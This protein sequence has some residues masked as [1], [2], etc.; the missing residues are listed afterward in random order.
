MKVLENVIGI[1]GDIHTQN[2]QLRMCIQYM[3]AE[4]V[5]DILCTGDIADGPGDINACIN[6]IREENIEIVLGNHDQWLMAE[7]TRKATNYS[8]IS[9]LSDYNKQWL[10]N[11][12]KTA[13]FSTRI[14][15][16]LLCHGLGSNDM[17]SLKP[18]DCGYSLE[19]NK[20]FNEI[21]SHSTYKLVIAGH[22]HIKMVR[23]IAGITFINPGSLICTSEFM[24]MKCAERM[25]TKIQLKN[26]NEFLGED[27]VF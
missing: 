16:M 5:H 4:N 21:V 10:K 15:N 12:P 26:R 23:T 2:I 20:E 24:I 11:V 18:T 3:R 1:I 8:N 13:E 9:Q 25:I 14:G 19:Y 6:T 17:G 7:P 27:L 22:T